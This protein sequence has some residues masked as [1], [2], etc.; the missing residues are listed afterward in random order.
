MEIQTEK[1]KKF[2]IDMCNG[3][4]FIKIIIFSLP[5]MLMGILQ[6]LYNAADLIVVG[7]FSDDKTAIGAIGSTSSLISLTVNLFMGLSVGTNVACAKYFGAKNNEKISNVVHTS[8]IIS[9]IMGIFL[10]IF[11]FIF[12]DDLLHLMHN[13]LELSRIYLK[14]YFIG[15]P[16]NL[17]YNFAAA[18]LRA[19]G[20]TKRPLYFLT[21][22]GL[23]NIILNIISVVVFNM[24]VAGVAYAT[25]LSQFISCILIMITLIKTKESYNFNFKK[26]RIHKQELLEI[27]KVGLPA[28]IQSSIFSISNVIIQSS[29]NQFGFIAMN[30][31]SAASSV[32]DFVYVSMESVYHASLAFT[33]QNVGAK[34]TKNIKKVTIYSLIIV[35]L[36]ATILGGSLFLLG[37]EAISIYTKNP[38]EIA[39]GYIRLHY[40]CLPYFLCGIM[41][42][43]VGILRGM[44]YS[45]LPMIISIIGI[46]GFRISWIYGYFYQHTDF[47][48]F[49]DLNM[50]YVSYPI[51][52]IITFLVQLTCYLIL[53]KK[54]FKQIENDLILESLI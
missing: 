39:V 26:A 49:K 21:I 10:G 32:E 35:T 37:K 22:A 27:L 50:L 1:K 42:V 28:G 3:N 19:V 8:I 54:R 23:A 24:G 17:V 11:G 46:C 14:I 52:W 44:G 18:V 40:L 16:F 9:L 47:T 15:M 30:G 12:A 53:S 45:T 2:E 41:D 13:D 25:I 36:I 4:L 29:V 48:N 34:K 33:S 7:N 6:L 43:M 51:S 38:D 31:N 5:L 20:D